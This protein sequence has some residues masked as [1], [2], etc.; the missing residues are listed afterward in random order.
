MCL[1][2]GI[3]SL[4][5]A[6]GTSAQLTKLEVTLVG[7]ACPNNP[8][9]PLLVI[10]G[11][12]AHAVP[13]QRDGAG[14]TFA[15]KTALDLRRSLFSLRLGGSRS[16]CQKAQPRREGDTYLG[17]LD[18]VCS[19]APVTQLRVSVLPPTL[20]VKYVRE[21]PKSGVNADSIKCEEFGEFQSSAPITDLRFPFER[22]ML[23][24]DVSER[25]AEAPALE[26]TDRVLARARRQR[27]RLERADMLDALAV[28]RAAGEH[29]P[30]TLASNARAA[31]AKRLKNLQRLTIEPVP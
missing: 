24:L 1:W 16:D 6:V 11:D 4:V 9:A 8:P 20:Q 15:S 21:L 19:A 31:D 23:Q 25:T 30:S 5:L 17:L 14:W 27:G 13:L 10:D 26:V 28:A 12:E 18:F 2:T 22:L 7:T 3:L 29:A